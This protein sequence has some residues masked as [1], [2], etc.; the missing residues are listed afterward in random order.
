MRVRVPKIHRTEANRKVGN[1]LPGKLPNLPPQEIG[2]GYKL[3]PKEQA[4]KQE[5][6]I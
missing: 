5:K 6:L 4:G 3:A 1:L 2:G